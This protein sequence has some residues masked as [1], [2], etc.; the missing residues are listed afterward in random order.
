[1][2]P[3][4]ISITCENVVSRAYIDEQWFGIDIG[5]TLTKG[6][7]F[8]CPHTSNDPEQTAAIELIRDFVKSSITYGSSGTRDEHLEI[9]EQTIGQRIGTLHFL[10]FH[11]CRMEGFLN[12]VSDHRLHDCRSVVCATG[13]G[14]IKFEKDINEVLLF[15][16]IIMYLLL[17]YRNLILS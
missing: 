2:Y 11:T 5:G 15:V 1:L 10:K 3:D 13:G 14:A 12:I 16:M 8:E 17:L 7:Y 9:R 4:V 6:V